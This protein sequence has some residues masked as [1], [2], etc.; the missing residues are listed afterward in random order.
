MREQMA[1][2]SLGLC[3]YQTLTNL[4]SNS[5]LQHTFTLSFCRNLNLK[6]HSSI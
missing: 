3:V 4:T 1:E 6:N 2:L 5:P